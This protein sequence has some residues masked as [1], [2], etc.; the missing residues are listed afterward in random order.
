MDQGVAIRE[1]DIKVIFRGVIVAPD[2]DIAVL[3]VETL[4]VNHTNLRFIL[5]NVFRP[6]FRLLMKFS[7]M[8]M[9]AMVRI[10]V[11]VLGGCLLFILVVMVIFVILIF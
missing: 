9:I 4:L 11:S 5:V 1:L 3:I 6:C 8:L 7:L 10:V 2:L